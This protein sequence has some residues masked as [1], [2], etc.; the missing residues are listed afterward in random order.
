MKK[1][2]NT[3]RFKAGDLAVVRSNFG[4]ISNYDH[5]PRIVGHSAVMSKDLNPHSVFLVLEDAKEAPYTQNRKIY[6]EIM[7]DAGA[8]VA[9]ASA[10]KMRKRE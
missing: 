6:V 1:K 9:W 3:L 8:Q 2:G 7:T 5:G 10:F 4:T